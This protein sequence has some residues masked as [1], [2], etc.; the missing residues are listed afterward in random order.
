MGDATAKR[1]LGPGRLAAVVV[2]AAAVAFGVWWFAVRGGT[3]HPAPA[4]P[5]GVSAVTAQNLETLAASLSAPIYWAGPQAGVTYELNQGTTGRTYIRYLPQ[6]VAIGSPADYLTV[7]TYAYPNAY[8]ITLGLAGE[9]G[10]VKVPVAGG[11][12]AFFEHSRP[13]NVYIAFPG[14][15]YQV[16]VF[17]PVAGQ[18]AQLVR[19]GKISRV[20]GAP[21]PAGGGAGARAVSPA[22]LAKA[23]AALGHPIFWAGPERRSTYE[24]TTNSSG[25]VYVRYLPPGVAVG[26]AKPYLT[27]ATYPVENAFAATTSASKQPNAITIPVGGGGVAFYSKALPG[28][29]YLAFPGVNEQVEVFDPSA[30]LARRTVAAGRIRQVS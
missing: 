22:G 1:R 16:E 3:S 25:W 2:V 13:T 27:I 17:A 15:D 21:Q 14:S 12:V 10:S 28:N 4:L 26:A 6:G 11:G 19:E 20:G 7:G 29:I 8:N 5:A 30:A 9:A 24:L 23:A 18:A